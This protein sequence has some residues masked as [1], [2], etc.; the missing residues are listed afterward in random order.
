MLMEIS[1]KKPN[2][3]YGQTKSEYGRPFGS[4]ICF[5]KQTDLEINLFVESLRKG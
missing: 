1:L 5:R 3:V 4:K 2:T